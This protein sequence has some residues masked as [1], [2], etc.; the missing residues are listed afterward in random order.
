MNVLI[1]GASSGIGLEL[2]KVFAREGNDLVL[3]ARGKQKMEALAGELRSQ[4][5][6]NVRVIEKD[7]SVDGSAEEVFGELANEQIDI[8]VNN[9]GIGDFGLFKDAG[10]EKY[11]RMMHLN[12]LTLTHLTKLFLPQMLERGL[13]KILN[14]ASTAA[15]M[16]GPLMSV[17]F[18]TKAYV[19]SFSEALANELEGTG[20]QVNTLCPGATKTEFAKT[21]EI[22]SDGFFSDKIPTG[23][24]VAEFA[25]AELMAGKRLSVHGFKNRMLIFVTKFVPRLVVMKMTR[26]IME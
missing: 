3:V 24:E 23:E 4:Y 7:L 25:Y 13:G 10:W 21:S 15:F 22:D 6:I 9:A 2:A 18:A 19:L 1:T 11:E 16:P 20:V 17:Y 8:L 26:R 5:K 12:M 14:V